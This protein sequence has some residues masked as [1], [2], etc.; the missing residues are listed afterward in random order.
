MENEYKEVSLDI[1]N[2][3]FSEDKRDDY[4]NNPKD[5]DNM[6]IGSADTVENF[7]ITTDSKDQAYLF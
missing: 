6:S 5:V 4:F 1:W 7:E 2:M 3:I